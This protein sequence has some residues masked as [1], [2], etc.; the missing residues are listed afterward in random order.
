MNGW[1]L[2]PGAHSAIRS[3]RQI[4]KTTESSH[5]RGST[6]P[7][8]LHSGGPGP[9]PIGGPTMENIANLFSA[10]AFHLLNGFFLTNLCQCYVC[11][12]ISV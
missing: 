11:C 1:S 3:M 7:S 8:G 4:M 9:V 5:C 12:V 2:S 6:G 10:F